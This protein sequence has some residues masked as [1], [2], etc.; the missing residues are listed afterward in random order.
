MPAMQSHPDY[1]VTPTPAEA[2]P[3]GWSRQFRM[4]L[5]R[6]GARVWYA[7]RWETVNYVSLRR[8][9]MLVHLS[10]HT[11]PV[12]SYALELEPTVFTTERVRIPH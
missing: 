6:P 12:D 4:P 10:G 5:F 9:D 8:N 2:T 1:L 7:G 11:E 3:W